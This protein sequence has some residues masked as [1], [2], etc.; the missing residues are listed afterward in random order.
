MNKSNT[1]VPQSEISVQNGLQP[2]APQIISPS[3]EIRNVSVATGNES[4]SKENISNEDQTLS[5]AFSVKS[6][7]GPLVARQSTVH[8]F[9]RY[10]KYCLCC[11]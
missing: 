3:E 10:G 7:A 4:C 5:S 8:P 6:S 2:E 1:E 9:S 11:N